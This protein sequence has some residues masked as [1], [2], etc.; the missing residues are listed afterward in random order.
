MAGKDGKLYVD[1]KW[2]IALVVSAFVSIMVKDVYGLPSEVRLTNQEVKHLKEQH[3]ADMQNIMNGFKG[4]KDGMKEISDN[5]K[6]QGKELKA[7][8]RDLSLCNLIV[9]GKR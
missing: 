8:G 9:K 2:V 6:A 1:I 7:Q 5:M 4:V 3:Q